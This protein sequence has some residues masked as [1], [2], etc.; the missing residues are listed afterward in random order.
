[1]ANGYVK[2]KN[3]NIIVYWF[4]SLQSQTNVGKQ[5]TL[6]RQ[7]IGIENTFIFRFTEFFR[8]FNFFI[9]KSVY[10]VVAGIGEI[11]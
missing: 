8:S 7:L 10:V 4:N 1:M 11:I 5:N 3:V 2:K 6:N 9:L